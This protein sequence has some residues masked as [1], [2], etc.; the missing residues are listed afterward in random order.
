MT[1]EYQSPTNSLPSSSGNGAYGYPN[2]AGQGSTPTLGFGQV[3]TTPTGPVNTSLLRTGSSNTTSGGSAV[4]PL[5]TP[6]LSIDPIPINSSGSYPTIAYQP[7]QTANATLSN[8]DTLNQ[9]IADSWNTPLSSILGTPQSTTSTSGIAALS[10]PTTM[11]GN[12][13][14]VNQLTRNTVGTVIN[15]NK[16]ATVDP[17]SLSYAAGAYDQQATAIGTVEAAAAAASKG[18]SNIGASMSS[19]IQNTFNGIG[20]TGAMLPLIVLG[21]GVFTIM[22][23]SKGVKA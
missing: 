14:S 6:M 16:P 13:P 10:S 23:L 20:M 17:T 8:Q 3:I 11:L 19:A 21:L 5:P 18:M 1:I 2:M 9:L 12:N 7:P 15:M 4:I 22:Y